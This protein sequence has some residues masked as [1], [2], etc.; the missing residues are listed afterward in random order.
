VSLAQEVREC[1]LALATVKRELVDGHIEL[2]VL[3]ALSLQQAALDLMREI[4]DPATVHIRRRR[5]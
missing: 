3:A 2:I 5:S 4:T 1:D